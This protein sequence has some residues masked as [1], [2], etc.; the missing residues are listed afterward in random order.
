MKQIFNHSCMLICLFLLLS[1]CIS[2]SIPTS[3]TPRYY[4]LDVLSKDSKKI[5]ISSDVIIGIGP[6]KVPENLDRPQIVTIRN[7]KT[8]K[9]AQF[10]RW[11]EYLDIGV[12]HVVRDNLTE[13]LPTAKITLYPWAPTLAVKYQVSIEIVQMDSDLG[14]D[15]FF[16]TQWIVKDGKNGKTIV[17]KSSEFREPIMPQS[18]AGLAKTLSKA[19]ASLSRE[20]AQTLATLDSQNIS[21][22][23][24]TL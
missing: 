19:C 16:V 17:V 21:L 8:L 20:I 10:D 22:L 9:I 14:Q 24:K 7:D 5:D 18:Y 11:G 4:A 2:L 6:V 3:P 12:A 15:L 1:G 23:G 13:I